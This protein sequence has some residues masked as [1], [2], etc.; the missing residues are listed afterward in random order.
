M[1]IA[2]GVTKKEILGIGIDNLKIK[3]Q[4]AIYH[5]RYSKEREKIKN[6]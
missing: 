1:P 2:T 6:L 3:Q 5:E 4:D